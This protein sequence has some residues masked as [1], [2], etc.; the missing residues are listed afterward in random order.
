MGTAGASL[1]GPHF[2]LFL[3]LRDRTPAGGSTSTGAGM[4]GPGVAA[5][6]G[7]EGPHL[8]C[9]YRSAGGKCGHV[10]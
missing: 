4:T 3:W 5:G 1:H 7:P 10:R 2:E 8:I 6:R 9:A